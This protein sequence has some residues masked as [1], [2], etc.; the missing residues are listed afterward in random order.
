AKPVFIDSDMDTWNMSPV[1]LRK[2]FEKY[3]EKGITPKAVVSV[4]LY[5]QSAKMD[6]IK[7]ICNQ[8]GSILI[9]DA[10]ESLGA[11]Y[12][13]KKSGTFGDFGIYS[14]NGNKIITTSGGGMLISNDEK[15]I[16]HALFLSTQS[17]DKALHYQ[18]SE[19]GFNYRLSNI[20][21]GIGRGQ[22]E[23]LDQRI[24]RRREIFD[25]YNA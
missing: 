23:V 17:R 22:M 24:Q 2:A 25:K 5:G 21:A 19:L 15:S 9:E 10:A 12:N 18:H 13:G 20:S 6:E 8:Y 7:E 1:A 4:N 16:A 3:A 14:F 11:E